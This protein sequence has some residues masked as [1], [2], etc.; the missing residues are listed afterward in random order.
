MC[1]IERKIYDRM[2]Y[3]EYKIMKIFICNITHEN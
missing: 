1:D 2:K 3:L